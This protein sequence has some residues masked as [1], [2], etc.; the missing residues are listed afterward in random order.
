MREEQPQ[1]PLRQASAPWGV[2]T[3]TVQ[4]EPVADRVALPP[5]HPVHLERIGGLHEGKQ[6]GGVQQLY[7]RC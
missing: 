1:S 4:D 7:Q 5:Q 2:M 6:T 3:W